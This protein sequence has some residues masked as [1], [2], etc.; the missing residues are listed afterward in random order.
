MPLKSDVEFAMDHKILEARGVDVSEGGVAFETSEPL[1]VALTVTV[2]GETMT[3]QARLV[4]ILKD[5][6]GKFTFG[7]EFAD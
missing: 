3:R 5:D 1:H 2:D 6:D 4:R 7:L